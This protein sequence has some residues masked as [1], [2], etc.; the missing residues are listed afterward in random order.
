MTYNK[1]D[2]NKV[3]MILFRHYTLQHVY[4]VYLPNPHT[5]REIKTQVGKVTFMRISAVLIIPRKIISI[6]SKQALISFLLINP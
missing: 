6:P 2:L 5:K 1:T 3:R 4:Q